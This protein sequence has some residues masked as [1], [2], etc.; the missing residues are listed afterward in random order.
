[1]RERMKYVYGELEGAFNWCHREFR[2]TADNLMRDMRSMR[3]L[4]NYL[5]LFLYIFLCVWAAVNYA[6]DSLNTAIV[7]T[8]GI[9]SSIFM[10]YVWGTTKEK[11]FGQRPISPISRPEKPHENE[12]GAS[13]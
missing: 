8:G 12:E 5:Y 1:M 11:E 2:E 6:K 13:D 4:F 3:A 7:T 10:A 9:V